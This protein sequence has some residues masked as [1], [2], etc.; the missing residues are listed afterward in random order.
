MDLTLYS[1]SGSYPG[2]VIRSQNPSV[3][4]LEKGYAILVVDPGGMMRLQ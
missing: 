4:S 3:F 2:F 1:I